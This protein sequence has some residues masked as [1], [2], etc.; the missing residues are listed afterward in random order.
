MNQIFTTDTILL[1]RKQAAGVAFS[2]DEKL[3]TLKTV[4]GLGIREI[5][6]GISATGDENRH[7]VM[8]IMKLGLSAQ[9]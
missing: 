8:S 9:L 6:C 1:S 3:G 5:E 4:N 2:K 7:A